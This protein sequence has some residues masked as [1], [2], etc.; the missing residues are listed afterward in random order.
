MK[1][2]V[3]GSGLGGLLAACSFAKKG[4]KVDVYEKL[5]YP[6]GRFTNIEY[7]GYQLSTGALHMIPYSGNG[8][9]GTMLKKLDADVEIVDSKPQ[10]LFNIEGKN[11]TSVEVAKIFPL[12]YKAGVLKLFAKLKLDRGDKESFDRWV[13]KQVNSEL[14]LKI[15]D[16][17]TGWS[18]SLDASEVSSKEVLKEIR[19]VYKYGGP[20]VPMGGCGGVTRAL[21]EV[22]SAEGGKLHLKNSVEKIYGDKHAEG[23]I[24]EGEKKKYDLIVSNAGLKATASLAGELF[25]ENYKKSVMNIK[26]SWGIKIS[27]ASDKPMLDFSGV[28]LTPYAERIHGINEITN[29]SPELAPQG[30][31]LIMSH[32]SL[33]PDRNI[34]LEIEKGIKDLKKIFPDFNKHCKILATQVY[35]KDWPVSR[36]PSG[37]VISPKTPVRNIVNVGDAIKPL[38]LIET[39]GIAG[40]VKEAISYV[41]RELS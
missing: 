11:L 32:Q 22:L 10:A 36:I 30:E 17:F 40:G 16:A 28:L 2:C 12:R 8:P 33:K 13:K 6:G 37:K 1:V 20:G 18:L 3:I 15:A 24:V 9:L 25:P 14:A 29:I 7:K 4:Y 39:D 21:F 38:G 34:K 26:S 31:H 41:E 5:P 23:V 19:N 35:R 27:V